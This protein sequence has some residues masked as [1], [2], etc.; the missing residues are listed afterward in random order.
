MLIH[1]SILKNLDL[2]RSTHIQT[3]FVLPEKNAALRV[4]ALDD[5]H[6]GKSIVPLV[7]VC[8]A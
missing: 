4:Y 7:Y 8:E 3:L 1:L 5:N 6:G 2:M